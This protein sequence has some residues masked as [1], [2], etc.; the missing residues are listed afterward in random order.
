MKRFPFYIL[1]IMCM[2]AQLS[3]SDDRETVPA[4]LTELCDVY[5]D[6]QGIASTAR[7]DDGTLLDI[8][9][10][11]LKADVADT[12]VRSVLTYAWQN[13]TP[14][15]YANSPAMCMS[16]RP[17]REFVT[18]AHDPVKLV[19]I[20]QCG[21]YINLVLGEMTRDKAAHEYAFSLD[22]LHRRTLC[23]SLLHRQPEED[24]PSYTKKRYASLPVRVN[25]TE[26][27]DSLQVS[28][29]TFEGWRA[30]LFPVR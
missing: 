19:S 10:Q 30:F 24:A 4:V 17:V 3:C 23:V 27:Y 14:R 1:Y 11:G 26:A 28:V 8:A 6:P 25:G 29:F 15:V 7:L 9:P 22:S 2:G 12:T 21:G 20:W 5:I 16:A 18:V 13:G